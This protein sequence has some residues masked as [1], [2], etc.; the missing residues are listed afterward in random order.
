MATALLKRTGKNASVVIDALC[1]VTE[2][3][4]ADVCFS[5]SRV[6]PQRLMVIQDGLYCVLNGAGWRTVAD[7]HAKREDICEFISSLVDYTPG[8]TAGQRPWNTFHAHDRV[9]QIT[10]KQLDILGIDYFDL[11]LI[12]FPIA[13]Q[14]VDPDRRYLLDETENMLLSETWGTMEELNIGL[15]N[16]QGSLI[17]DVLR[18][19]KYEP[20]VL[21]VELHPDLTQEMTA[22]PSFGPQSYSE[23]GTGNDPPSTLLQHDPVTII[24]S[25]HEKT[26]AQRSIAVIPKSNGPSRQVANLQCDNFNLLD[27]KIATEYQLQGG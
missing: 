11:I 6:L 16:C 4:C 15:S 10:K 7:G 23:P 13:L 21:Q 22:Y 12:H 18:Y 14:C 26:T 9:K 3:S 2:S 19:A 1:W 27:A 5:H 20:Q 8:L 25:T 17:L 24:A